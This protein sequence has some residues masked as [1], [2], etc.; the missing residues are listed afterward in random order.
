MLNIK[1]NVGIY[2]FGCPTLTLTP[3]LCMLTRFVGLCWSSW[4]IDLSLCPWSWELLWSCWLCSFVQPFVTSMPGIYILSAVIWTKIRHGNFSL[5][6]T[7]KKVWL[8]ITKTSVVLAIINSTNYTCIYLTFSAHHMYDGTPPKRK[9]NRYNCTGK[10]QPR[11][12]FL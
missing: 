12:Q 9:W 11:S 6:N 7:L 8:F 4:V 1:S 10:L 3:S 5:P 2:R